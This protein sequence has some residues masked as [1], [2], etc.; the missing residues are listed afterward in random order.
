MKS[1]KKKNFSWNWLHEFKQ[2]VFWQKKITLGYLRKNLQITIVL[3]EKNFYSQNVFT[4][5]ISIYVVVGR[6]KFE[7]TKKF[8]LFVSKIF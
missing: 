2:I 7:L 4:N 5:I 6:L 1:I 8:L 3:E